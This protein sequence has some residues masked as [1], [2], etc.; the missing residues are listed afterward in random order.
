MNSVQ[1]EV[2][3]IQVSYKTTNTPK[4]KISTAKSAYKVFLSTWNLDTIELQEEF[5]IMLLN[6]ANS[7]LGIYSLSKGGITGTV[8]DQRLVLQLL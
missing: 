6:R 5:K 7:L 3:E 8:V 4:E 1:D 2:A